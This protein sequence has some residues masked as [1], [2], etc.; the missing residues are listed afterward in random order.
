[1]FDS[2]NKKNKEIIEE[3]NI[4]KNTISI[5]EEL[6]DKKLNI[7]IKTQSDLVDFINNP[8]KYIDDEAIIEEIK[9]LKELV[10]EMSDL[11]NE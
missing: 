10:I 11:Y 5:L 6:L 9:R 8:E 7:E 4:L 2:P 1:M 3:K